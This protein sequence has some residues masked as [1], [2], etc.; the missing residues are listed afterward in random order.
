MDNFN[1]KEYAWIDVTLVMLGKPVTGLRGIEYKMKRQKEALF[2]TGKKAR[3]I[4]LGKKEYE[5]TI[6][7]LQ[8]ELIAMQTAAKAKGYDDVTDLEFDAIVSYV[9]ESGVVQT[10]KIVNLS[11]TEAPYGMKEGDLFQEI[12]LP[13]IAC[14]V[15]PNVV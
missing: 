10:D 15:E 9:P 11:I 2:A 3:G 5:G 6:T 13:F 8:S 1:S 12:A 7:V 4:Q 14:D